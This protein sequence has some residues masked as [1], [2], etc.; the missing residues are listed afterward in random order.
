MTT[1]VGIKTNFKDDAVVLAADSQAT[2]E[3]V[4]ENQFDIYHLHEP[5]QSKLYNVNNGIIG[6]SGDGGEFP[7]GFHSYLR[8]ERSY[9]EYLAYLGGDEESHAESG[10]P[11][12]LG[13]NYSILLERIDKL[14]RKRK[15]LSQVESTIKSLITEKREPK[16][17]F[18]E[19]ITSFFGGFGEEFKN[20]LVRAADINLRYF[21]EFEML[22]RYASIRNLTDE[23]GSHLLFAI[24]E[25]E[26][27]LYRCD[28][29][30]IINSGSSDGGLEYETIGSGKKWVHHYL[31]YEKYLE[32]KLLKGFNPEKVDL[33]AAK[34]LALRLVGY[35]IE[36]DKYSGGI[37]DLAV[38]RE[39]DIK[40]YGAEI[41]KAVRKSKQS[42][43]D[44][45]K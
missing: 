1:I 34:N 2:S 38:V 22:N 17:E 35:A 28:S 19:F 43:Y 16:D 20:P 24:N 29:H 37:I 39:E 12:I 15:N 40:H 3:D 33:E 4:T 13:T 27:G 8:G 10:L 44:G 26:I 45:I 7:E 11:F 14:R 18:E 21:M 36:K 25:P 41:R 9:D 6:L 42:I 23:W 31:G 32:D 30:G 5:N